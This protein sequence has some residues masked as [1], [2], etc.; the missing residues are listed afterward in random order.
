[1]MKMNG[2]SMRN[3]WLVSFIFKLFLSFLTNAIFYLFGYFIVKNTFFTETPFAMMFVVLFGWMLSQIGM[4]TFFQ[5]FL[6]N[7]RSANIIGYL[8]SIWTSL[9][10][11]SLNVGVYQ[12]PT[13]MPYGMRMYPP[14]GFSRIFY[15]MLNKCSGN[16][17]F[18]SFKAIPSEMRDEIVYLY[19]G[20]LV[21]QLLGM[22]L[23][24]V[25]PQ[26]FGVAKPLLYPIY[27][28]KRF[29]KKRFSRRGND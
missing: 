2:M 6:S 14:F 1:M 3:Y 16:E 17:C 15:I 23:H 27:S 10:G 24:E 12:Y 20:F 19:V 18:N 26:E 25:I 11:A 28:F 5:T 22:Y 29:W 13:E 21:F 8:L 9:V 4:A 7:S